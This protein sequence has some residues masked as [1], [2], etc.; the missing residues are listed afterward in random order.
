MCTGGH[1]SR[2]DC[3][4][5][6][7]FRIY[8]S[9]EL[10]CAES[11]W[12]QWLSLT[13]PGIG[14]SSPHAESSGHTSQPVIC[15][16][17]GRPRW[18]PPDTL[19]TQPVHLSGWPKLLD[20][21]CPVQSGSK[22]FRPSSTFVIYVFCGRHLRPSRCAVSLQRHARA[23]LRPPCGAEPFAGSEGTALA[24]STEAV[25]ADPSSHEASRELQYPVLSCFS[26][27]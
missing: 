5:S 8:R 12:P 24:Q 6:L 14:G 22:S 23:V 9:G 13:Y 1:V 18:H 20:P 17:Q 11:S 7:C 19:R 2:W 3:D 25:L 26:I 10:S 16:P 15:L 21:T 4:F 27:G